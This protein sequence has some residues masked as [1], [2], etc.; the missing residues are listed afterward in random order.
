MNTLNTTS[1]TAFIGIDWADAK[2]DICIQ[3]ADGDEREFDVIPHQVE[4]IDEWAH[5]MRQR[6]GS[7]IAVAVELSKG[8]IVYALQKH[9]CFVIFPVNPTTLA[10]YREA[11]QP[12]RAKDDPT[13]AELAVDLILRHPERFKP[14]HPQSTEMRTLATLVE[15]RRHLVDDKIRITNRLRVALKQYYPQTLAWFDHIDTPLFCD[16]LTRWP[17]LLQAKRA[18]KNTLKTFFHGH[19][20]RFEQVLEQ[21]LAAIKTASPLTLDEAV[22]VPYRLQALVLVEQ[23]RVLLNAIKRFDTE[24]ES[25]AK[26]HIDYTLFSALPGAG[27]TLAPRLLVAFGEQRER[28]RNAADVQKYSGIAPVT[29]RSGKKHWVHWRWQCPTFLRQ[30]FI[31][32]AAQ[33]INKSFWAGEYYRQQRAKGCTYQAAVRALAFKW[34]RIL[35]RCWQTRTP[36]DEVTYLKALERRGSPLLAARKLT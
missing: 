9:D 11:F 13:D 16:F 32:W 5:T 27:P 26:A 14:L 23:L 7:P 3:S 15:Q 19:N 10:K 29:E 4:R 1:F 18:R 2:H 20:M 33:T 22:I 30:T 28:Y 34:I 35:Y 24:I 31:E 36:Y 25:V 12:S 8:P 17:T 6:F 21:R